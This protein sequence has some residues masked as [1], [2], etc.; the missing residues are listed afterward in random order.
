MNDKIRKI[1]KDI[2]GIIYKT[3][4]YSDFYPERFNDLYLL[5]TYC[6]ERGAEVLLMKEVLK[7]TECTEELFKDEIEY[8]EEFILDAKKLLLEF[9]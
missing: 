3:T 4:S 8:I 7:E 2:I 5:N 1:E 9:D 6:C